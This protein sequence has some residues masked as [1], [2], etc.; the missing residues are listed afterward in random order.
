LTTKNGTSATGFAFTGM[1]DRSAAKAEPA[2][3][4]VRPNA[5]A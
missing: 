1:V 5:S 2:A 3:A 4:I